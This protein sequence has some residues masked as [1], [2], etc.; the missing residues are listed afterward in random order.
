[1]TNP[2]KDNFYRML[3]RIVRLEGE[4]VVV[5]VPGQRWEDF[6]GEHYTDSDGLVHPVFHIP[7]IQ[8][9]GPVEPDGYAL[10]KVNLHAEH[11][12]DVVFKDFEVAPD[13]DPDDDIYGL[14]STDSP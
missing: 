10:A 12:G 4:H 9:A 1:M 5:Y 6:T 14:T 3:L 8:F 13:P 11:Q 7:A 2:Y